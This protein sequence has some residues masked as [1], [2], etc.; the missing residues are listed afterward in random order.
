MKARVAEGIGGAA[1]VEQQQH[2]D[3]NEIDIDDLEDEDDGDPGDGS[4]TGEDTGSS[5]GGLWTID[6]EGEKK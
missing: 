2:G 6:R 5:S 4:G 3:D 1:L